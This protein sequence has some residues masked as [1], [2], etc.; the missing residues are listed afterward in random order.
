MAE[1]FVDYPQGRCSSLL[2]PSIDLIAVMTGFNLPAMLINFLAN[3]SL[4]QIINVWPP[5][6]P[7]I[8]PAVLL[9][10]KRSSASLTPISR[11]SF[12]VAMACTLHI[13]C[14]TVMIFLR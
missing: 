4:A 7:K 12:N 2:D 1:L 13:F 10:E 14:R 3:L 6:V 11:A 5:Q 8:S 9:C